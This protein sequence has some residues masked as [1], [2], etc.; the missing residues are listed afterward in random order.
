MVKVVLSSGTSHAGARPARGPFFLGQRTSL[1]VSA[2]VVVG[3]WGATGSTAP[4][5]DW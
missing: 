1:L 5:A 2:S 4:T 3:R